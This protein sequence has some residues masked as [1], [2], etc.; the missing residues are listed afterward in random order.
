MPFK[1]IIAQVAETP[2]EEVERQNTDERPETIARS[3]SS[4]LVVEAHSQ[5][6][7]ARSWAD[8]ETVL[9]RAQAAYEQGAMTQEE[10]ETLAIQATQKARK[11]PPVS[12]STLEDALADEKGVVK[13][14]VGW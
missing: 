2:R 4:P 13:Q 14:Q 12:D 11:L 10:V 5:I 3:I 8:L 9:D 6:V 7:E 1:S